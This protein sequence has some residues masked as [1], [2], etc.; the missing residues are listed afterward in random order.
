MENLGVPAFSPRLK[1]SAIVLAGQKSSA[2]LLSGVDPVGER[3]VTF[4]SSRVTKGTYVSDGRGILIGD[5]LAKSIGVDIGGKVTVMTQDRTGLPTTAVFPVTGIYRT[6]LSSFDRSHVYL[7]LPAAQ[8]LLRAEGAVSEIAARTERHEDTGIAEKLAGQ[9]S[10]RR[11]QVRT[12]QEIAPDVQ[13]LIQLN[14]AT[15]RLL[16]LIVFT[17]IAMGIANTMTMAIF[18]RIR[19]MGILAAIGTSPSGILTMIVMESFLLGAIASIAGSIG[20]YGACAYLAEYG[21]DLT[22]LTSANQYFATSHVLKAIL[23]P[24]DLA[25]ANAVTLATALV[26]GI[27]PALKAARLKP[28]EAISHT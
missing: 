9:L 19:E 18:E 12:W 2:V 23:R 4:I 5:A 7:A 8:D 10:S 15:M 6:D 27:Y 14:E 24:Q 16:I 25:A 11:Y 20:A 1:A 21:I 17:I 13:Q 3:R 28:A 26:G 22:T